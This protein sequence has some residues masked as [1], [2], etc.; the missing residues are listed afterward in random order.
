MYEKVRN[1]KNERIEVCRNCQG[2]GIAYTVPEFHHY[3]KEDAP[4]PYECPVC[5]GSGRIRKT[6]N[7][8]ITIEPYRNDSKA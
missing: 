5:K 8:E 6:Q 7:I 3:G 2:T 1:Y 4:E